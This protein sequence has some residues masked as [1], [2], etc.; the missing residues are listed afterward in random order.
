MKAEKKVAEKEA[1][2]KQQSEK[3]PNKPALA[4][5]PENGLGTDEESVDPNV[6]CS[7]VVAVRISLAA[8]YLI[9]NRAVFGES[10]W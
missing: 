7:P 3:H 5:G 1:K 10:D 8:S 6:S 4:P 2:Q 9:S